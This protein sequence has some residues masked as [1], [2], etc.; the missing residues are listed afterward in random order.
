ML[1][2]CYDLLLR[3]I[4]PLMSSV[5]HET[6]AET[7]S[8]CVCFPL[9][10]D[11]ERELSRQA[12][13]ASNGTM[14]ASMSGTDNRTVIKHHWYAF[15]DTHA[16]TYTYTHTHTHSKVTLPN[17]ILFMC[18]HMRAGTCVGCK[19]EIKSFPRQANYHLLY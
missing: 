17:E 2:C 3:Q 7:H 10:D 16:I 8:A 13:I 11:D 19:S 18:K 15:L 4:F 6:L 5:S 14:R 1:N 9:R 12:V